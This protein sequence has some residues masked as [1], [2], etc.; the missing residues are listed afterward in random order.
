MISYGIESADEDVLSRSEK[1]ITAQ[2]SIR[3][4]AAARRV[5]LVV[6]GHFIFGLPGDSE[7]RMCKT[8]DLALAL[9]LDIGQ[10]YAASP[11]PG[12]PLFAEARSEG[13]LA[14]G[15]GA[16]DRSVMNLPGLPAGRV[17]A[18][19]RLAFRKFYLRPR[20]IARLLSLVEPAALPH[21]AQTFLRFTGWS[22]LLPRR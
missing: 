1:N 22:R 20:V 9:P 3:A 15:P 14:A 5:G 13:W 17:D 16:Q 18:F 10:F 8:L 6:S 21:L 19:R 2:Q 12:T 11:F 7:S 4:V